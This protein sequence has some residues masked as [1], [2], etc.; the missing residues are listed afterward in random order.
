MSFTK[1]GLGIDTG[2]IVR[3]ASASDVRAECD[4]S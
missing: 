1:F 3:S 2:T 4:A